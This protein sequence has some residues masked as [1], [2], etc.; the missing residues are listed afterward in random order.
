MGGQRTKKGT[1]KGARQYKKSNTPSAFIDKTKEETEHD[2]TMSWEDFKKTHSINQ[3][4]KA[5]KKS[6]N[7]DRAITMSESELRHNFE[8]VS[9]QKRNGKNPLNESECKQ[10]AYITH[11][12]E[13]GDAQKIE[14]GDAF[15]QAHCG[16]NE[17]VRMG[18]TTD[19]G[20]GVFATE[21]IP[22]GTTVTIYPASFFAE[23]KNGHDYWSAPDDFPDDQRIGFIRGEG[24]KYC[25]K[26]STHEFIGHP[27]RLDKWFLLG[28][29]IN[30]RGYDGTDVY[31]PYD[32]NNC[33]YWGNEV[34]TFRDIQEGEELGITY[35]GQ[36]WFEPLREGSP[37]TNHDIYGI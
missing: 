34:V 17:S 24:R 4:R 12:C 31:K 2:W 33:Y 32:N 9:E 37:Q 29:M 19:I 30:D 27:Q 3:M 8:I 5:L 23:K 15:L 11:C 35:G 36:Y 18:N 16:N 22:K 10:M 1:R 7:D 28:H 26:S 25:M 20:L 14:L 21:D 6:L 13:K